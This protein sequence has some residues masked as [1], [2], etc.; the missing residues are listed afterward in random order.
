MPRLRAVARSVRSRLDGLSDW[1]TTGE[2]EG[3][4]RHD[5][6]ADEVAVESLLAA[7][8]GVVSEESGDH[9]TERSLV[10][11]VDPV[12]GSTNASLGVPWWATSICVVD[13]VGPLA[14]VVVNQATGVSYDAVRGA[15]ARRDG[16]ALPGSRTAP[17]RG[18][19]LAIVTTN[20]W[21]PARPPSDQYRCL[22]ASALDLCGV[23]DRTFDAFV[24]NAA[25]GLAPWDYY[26]A[27]LVCAEAGALT[28]DIWGRGLLVPGHRDRRA[29]VAATTASLL[30]ELLAD[31]LGTGAPH[32]S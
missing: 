20:G 5:V 8:L 21:P 15:G 7:G 13:D 26:G 25:E 23:A 18:E 9:A 22:G 3:Q 31:R 10:A 32:P 12:D 14:A 27:M 24:D 28:E 30:Q 2:R 1:G 29:P 11:V 17:G 19:R 16:R 6:V 4:Y